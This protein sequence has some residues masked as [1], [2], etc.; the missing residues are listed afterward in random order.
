MKQKTITK[1][2]F[3]LSLI[4]VF[5]LLILS[6]NQKPIIHGKIQKI[7]YGNNKIS[8]FLQNNQIEIVLFTNQILNLQKDQQ[9]NVYGYEEKY[10]DK[11]QIIVDKIVT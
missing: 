9:I 5:I 3:L 10:K 7:N 8:I 4:G 6:Q 11:Q 2:L 1:I